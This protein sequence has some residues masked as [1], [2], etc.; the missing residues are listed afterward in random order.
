[1]ALF[2][3][4]NLEK[5]C[6][7]T[8]RRPKS[9][10]AMSETA[11]LSRPL[12]HWNTKTLRHNQYT[13]EVPRRHQ[14]QHTKTRWDTTKTP[15]K[16]QRRNP[17]DTITHR[18]HGAGI[19]A[20]IWGRLMVNVTIYGIH[21]SYGLSLTLEWTLPRHHRSTTKDQD[22]SNIPPRQRDTI[23]ISRRD[24]VTET[25][26][27]QHWDATNHSKTTLPHGARPPIELTI[28]SYRYWEDEWVFE[29]LGR[30]YIILCS[31]YIYIQ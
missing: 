16:R 21:G 3:E 28:P 30:Y 18:I 9:T 7:K 27:K 14:T 5:R 8:P 22:A 24:R 31:I 19:Y 6:S 2:T 10:T 26:P 29:D 12:G 11:R 17:W 25:P 23:E 15:L 4:R 13:I 1:M 20:N